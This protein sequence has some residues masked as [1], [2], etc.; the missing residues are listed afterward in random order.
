MRPLL[1]AACLLLGTL[2]AARA[3]DLSPAADRAMWCGAAFAVM[4]QAASGAEAGA[5]GD[6]ADAAFAKAAAELVATGMSVEDFGALAEEYAGKI[7]SPFRKGGYSQA[8]CE[9]LVVGQ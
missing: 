5:F 4:Q 8:E 2:A 6:K 3:Q 1:A 9:A 7:V